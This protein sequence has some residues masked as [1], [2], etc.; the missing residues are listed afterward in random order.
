MSHS[1]ESAAILVCSGPFVNNWPVTPSG[2]YA[3][4]CFTGEC[5]AGEAVRRM[6]QHGESP[7]LGW[8]VRDMPKGKEMSG[9]E[10][11]FLGGI[12]KMA[13]AS[14]HAVTVNI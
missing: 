5:L 14:Q 13:M 12:A 8:M 11:G 3:Q 9:I 10:I 6:K 1:T 4:D 2:N 7:L